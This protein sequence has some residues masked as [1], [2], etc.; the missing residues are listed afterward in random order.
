M[1]RLTLIDAAKRTGNEGTIGVVE[2]L[3]LMNPFFT[4]APIKSINGAMYKFQRRSALPSVG[5]RGYNEGVASTKSVIQDVIVE[6]KNMLGV[7]EVDKALADLSKEGVQMFRSKEDSAY[8]AAMGQTFASK[9]YYGSSATTAAD[10]DGVGTVLGTLGGTCISATGNTASVQTSMYFWSFTDAVGITGRLPGVEIPV[11]NGSL[12]SAMDLGVQMVLDSGGSN[13][14]PA[15]TTIF[16]FHP[17]LAIYDTRSVGRL[18]NIQAAATA[19]PPT[20]AL[21]NQVITAMMPYT[22]DLITC[23]KATYNSIQGLKGTT[24]TQTA[25]YVSDDI[26]KR[27]A[28]FNGIPILVDENIT[29]TEAVVA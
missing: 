26:F 27:A 6:C 17:G 4:L 14:F 21:I 29:A 1:A 3:S 12:P 25:P 8:L 11:A 15:Y 20:V 23:S 24:F 28:Y 22:C 2:S 16:E 10:I 9:A 7:S 13:K 5:F 19:A 18:A